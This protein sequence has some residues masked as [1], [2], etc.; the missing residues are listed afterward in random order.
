MFLNTSVLHSKTSS[1]KRY[2]PIKEATDAALYS[3]KAAFS[4]G[5]R[6]KTTRNIGWT[7]DWILRDPE[8]PTCSL[9]K[10]EGPP[11]LTEVVTQPSSDPWVRCS[12]IPN[13]IFSYK[14]RTQTGLPYTLIGWCISLALKT[15]KSLSILGHLAG[16]VGRAYDSW[17]L[18][19]E[20]EP[21]L[22]IKIT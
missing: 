1:I 16:S 9:W 17:S 22:G 19:Y 14:F 2:R 8:S 18:G 15:L 3:F 11:F 5:W 7:S 13:Y 10:P 20:S 4:D 12:S 6:C 21:T